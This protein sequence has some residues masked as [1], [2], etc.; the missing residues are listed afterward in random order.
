[1]GQVQ[2]QA[3]QALQQ[4]RQSLASGLTGLGSQAQQAAAADIGMLTSM[5][6]QQQQLR[7]S[8]L[9]AQRQAL[10]SAQQAPLAQYTA[11]MPFVSMAGQQT[12]PSKTQ[13]AFALP[14]NA[15][16]AALSAGL[17]AFGAF[18][19]FQNQQQALAQNQQFLNQQAQQMGMPAPQQQ[20]PVPQQAPPQGTTTLGPA[21][22]IPGQ[23]PMPPIN[24]DQ[25]FRFPTPGQ[26]YPV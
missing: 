5:G 19:Q 10:L 3:G 7:Q 25:P 15:F 18:G 22:F 2:G 16:N 26:Q 21:I 4:G 1:M 24:T 14:P 11:L 8:Q 13:T 12:G 23:T 17:G 9:D 6:Q 20:Q